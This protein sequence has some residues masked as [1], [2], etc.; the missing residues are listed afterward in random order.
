MQDYKGQKYHIY[1]EADDRLGIKLPVLTNMYTQIETKAKQLSGPQF[2]NELLIQRTGPDGKRFQIMVSDRMA[3]HLLASIQETINQI[4]GA[5]V[6]AHFQGLQESLMKQM[7][8][9]VKDV[10]QVG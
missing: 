7:F 3:P 4:G 2:Q 6:R 5:S 1:A 10:I 8:A 9:N